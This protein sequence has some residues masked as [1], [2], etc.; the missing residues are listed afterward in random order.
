MLLGIGPLCQ[1]DATGHDGFA[2][3]MRRG[4]VH[5]AAMAASLFSTKLFLPEGYSRPLK[6]AVSTGACAAGFSMW[7]WPAS[8]R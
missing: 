4:L 8:A 3:R 6:N 1:T 7:F 5:M 2:S